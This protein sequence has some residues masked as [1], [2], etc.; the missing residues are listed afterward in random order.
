M[1]FVT[2][3]ER[4]ALFETHKNVE[5]FFGAS[6]KDYTILV[7]IYIDGEYDTELSEQLK[8]DLTDYNI[9]LRRLMLTNPPNQHQYLFHQ[10]CIMYSHIV[11]KAFI[12]GVI[13]VEKI[14]HRFDDEFKMVRF[15]YEL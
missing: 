5:I 11:E 7:N 1:K 8:I 2:M 10:I 14:L 12:D 9:D 6:E 3:L 15:N 13:D 4:R